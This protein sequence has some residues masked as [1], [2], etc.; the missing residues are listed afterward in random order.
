MN[1]YK[2]IDR[3]LIENFLEMIGAQNPETSGSNDVHML[4]EIARCWSTIVSTALADHSAAT[5]LHDGVLS[6]KADHGLFAQQLQM[7]QNAILRKIVQTTGIKVKK[8]K[9]TVGRLTYRNNNQ[10]QNK[11]SVTAKR[12]LTEE[13]KKQD[14]VYDDLIQELKKIKKSTQESKN[15]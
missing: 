5:Y 8:I 13:Q 15:G 2:R 10:Q 6:V 4:R 3:Q 7:N 14:A 1:D 9:V 11:F 12:T